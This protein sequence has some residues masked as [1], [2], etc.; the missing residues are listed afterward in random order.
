MFSYRHGFHAGNHADVLKH[1]VLVQMLAY[2]TAKDKPL[3]F[4]D[5]HAGAGSYSLGSDFA[6]KKSEFK[7]G[8]GRL[9]GKAGLPAP[10]AE[11]LQQVQ[12]VNPDGK[13]RFYP[14]SPQ[15]A[16]QMLRAQDR[17]QLFEL[18]TTESEILKSHF[19]KFPRRVSVQAADGF[20]GL[21]AV[22][23]PASRRG[24]V[25][26]DPS[27]EDKADYRKVVATVRDALK[28]FATGTYAV[29]YPQVQRKESAQLPAQLQ[30]LAEGD[31]LHAWLRVMKP[32]EDGLGLHGS[33]MF[34]FNPPWKLEER[35]RAA[36]PAL[37]KL[38]GQDGHAA[39]GL[40]HRQA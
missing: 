34:V 22:L 7:D 3:W 35:L 37:V 38:L 11:Y 10:L 14:G 32:A 26:I 1:V 27:Y 24:L 12:A 2:L 8:I 21:K 17:L 36:L 5:T 33:G 25:L 13:L 16:Q 19:A 23:P 31:W 9:W 20:A 29:W 6:R 40:Q 39:H 4:V 30:Q 15:I 28:R 18:H